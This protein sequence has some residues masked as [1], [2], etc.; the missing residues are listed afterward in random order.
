MI[1]PEL[2]SPAGD[3]NCLK[4]AIKF[5]ADAVYVGGPLLQLRADKAAFSCQ[6][7]Y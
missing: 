6:I 2:L 1:K 7:P 4:T 5:G 3:M